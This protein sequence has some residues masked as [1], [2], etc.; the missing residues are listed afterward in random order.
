MEYFLSPNIKLI[1]SFFP[2]CLG[3]GIVRQASAAKGRHRSHPKRRRRCPDCEKGV[4]RLFNAAAATS[5]LNCVSLLLHALLL[6]RLNIYLQQTKQKTSNKIF[7]N[8]TTHRLRKPPLFRGGRRRGGRTQ[9]RTD[10]PLPELRPVQGSPRRGNSSQ[11]FR[12]R[13]TG[14]CWNGCS[15][16]FRRCRR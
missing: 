7:G 11:R 2:Q 9:T 5:A 8:F 4:K 16:R 10:E 12:C 3:L 6:N 15:G 13:R 14:T 1:S